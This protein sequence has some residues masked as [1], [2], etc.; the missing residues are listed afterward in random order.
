VPP[1][2]DGEDFATRAWDSG[3]QDLVL[4]VCGGLVAAPASAWDRTRPMRRLLP[5]VPAHGAPLALQGAEQLHFACNGCG[6]CCRRLRVA[7]THRDLER[8]TDSLQVTAASL[9]AWLELGEVDPSEEHASFVLLP[10]GPRLMVLAQDSGACR[11]LDRDAR[12]RAYEARPLDCQLYPFVFER[13][14]R[15]R[16]TRLLPFD[17]AGCGERREQAESFAKLDRMDA[18]RWSELE[19]YESLVSRWNRF[20]RHRARLHHRARGESEFFTFL[21]A[22]TASGR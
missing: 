21:S 6:E 15:K 20:A 17:P 19:E 16:A 13:D 22:A 14:S 9:V 3:R 7:L 8:L 1:C 5:V 11:L 12:C 4:R 2:E 10:G 18:A